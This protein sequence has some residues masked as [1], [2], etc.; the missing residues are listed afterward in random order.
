MPGLA[1]KKL[2]GLRWNPVVSTGITGLHMGQSH[3]R[4]LPNNVGCSQLRG[5]EKVALLC[6][7]DSNMVVCKRTSLPGGGHG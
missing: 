6:L 4:F 3:E 7:C 5:K 2:A 1:S